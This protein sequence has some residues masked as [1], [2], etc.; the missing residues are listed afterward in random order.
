MTMDD[1]RILITSSPLSRLRDSSACGFSRL[2][3]RVRAHLLYRH[4][5]GD[6]GLGSRASMKMEG[7]R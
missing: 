6:G 3:F 4:F 2:R 7:I 5:A 1:A